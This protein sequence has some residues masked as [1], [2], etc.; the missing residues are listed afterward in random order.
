MRVDVHAHV[1]PVDYLDM[2]DRFG[3]AEV[4]TA[5]AR[6]LMPCLLQL[7]QARVPRRFP[8]IKFI[9]SHLGGCLPF[10]MKRLDVQS[11][12]FM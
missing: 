11:P 3:G 12:W 9:S 5:I 10:L 7:M 4:G 1:Y 2:L 6:N 8:R